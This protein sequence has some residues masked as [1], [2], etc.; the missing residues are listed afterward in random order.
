MNKGKASTE[1]VESNEPRISQSMMKD[2]FDLQI[3][4]YKKRPDRSDAAKYDSYPWPEVCGLVFI[5]KFINHRFDL[6]PPSEAQK[7][8]TWFEYQCTKS[9]PKDGKV[10]Q[11]NV[12]KGGGLATDYKRMETHVQNFKNFMNHYQIEVL[13]VQTKWV[14]EGLEG[15]LDIL[16]K[17][18]APIKI[19]NQVVIEKDEEF[20]MDIKTTGL[21]DDK[22]TDYGWNLDTLYKKHRIILQPIHYKFLSMLKFGRE[23]KFLFLLFSTANDVDHRAILFNVQESE[24]ETHKD[25]IATSAQWLKFFLKKGFDANP[26]VVRCAKCPLRVGCKH[27]AAVPA[28]TQ[29]TLSNPNN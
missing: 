20:I 27:F 17:A 21:L 4:Y 9:L 1:V 22:W 16:A 8:G 29:F 6:F 19:G 13:D 5:E 23:Y 14:V 24:F 12:L 2:L 10:P 26:S 11:P 18:K 15:T 28:I 3:L 25:F 7:L